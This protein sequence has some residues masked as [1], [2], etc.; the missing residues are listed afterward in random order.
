VTIS[1]ARYPRLSLSFIGSIAA[2]ISLVFARTGELEPISRRR[3]SVE[4]GYDPAKE[5]ARPQGADPEK[6]YN[7]TKLGRTDQK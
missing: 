2:R 6:V 1:K 3:P 4:R 7:R 5:R